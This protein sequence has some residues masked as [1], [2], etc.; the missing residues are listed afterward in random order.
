MLVAGKAAGCV[1]T[2]LLTLPLH[3]E[4]AE[5]PCGERRTPRDGQSA[6]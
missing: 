2:V 6:Y 3:G 4:H 1:P 5:R